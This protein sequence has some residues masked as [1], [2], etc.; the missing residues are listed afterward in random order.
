MNGDGKENVFLTPNHSNC[1][2]AMND[3]QDFSV[4]EWLLSLIPNEQD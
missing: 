2:S 3:G 4:M 1:G